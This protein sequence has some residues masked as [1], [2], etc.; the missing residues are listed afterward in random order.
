MYYR[1]IYGP[2]VAMEQNQDLRK[3]HGDRG[4]LELLN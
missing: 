1:V 3:G 4:T 2:R